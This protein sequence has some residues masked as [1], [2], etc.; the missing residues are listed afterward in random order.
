MAGSRV[1]HRLDL[2][3]LVYAQHQ[4]AI[5]WCEVQANHV[6]H[7]LDE[8]RIRGEL[9]RVGLMRA[10]A[11]GAPDARHR[12]LAHARAARHRAGAPVCGVGWRLLQGEGDQALDGLV[13][14]AAGSPGAWRINQPLQPMRGEAG[15]PQRHGL[16][17]HAQS[18]C[19]AQIG[20]T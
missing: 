12:S 2:R 1:L 7:L 3:L 13:I 20:G 15:P 10:Q 9:E 5:G 8:S 18:P 11:E 14:D 16:P 19:D 6:A 4:R 17:A